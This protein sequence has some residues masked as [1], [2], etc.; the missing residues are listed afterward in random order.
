MSRNL[1]TGLD[2]ATA[3]ASLSPVILVDL[4]FPAGNVRCWN[5][6]GNITFGSNT[7]TGT[8]YLG[9]ISEIKETRD[10]AAN[11]I[12]VS[13]SGIPS[14]LV[15]LALVNNSQGQPAKVYL[16]VLNSSGTFSV[17]PY[18]IF[19]GVIDTCPISDDG[20]TATITVKLEKELIDTRTR[21]RRYTD[22]DQKIDY[23]TDNGLEYV[24]GLQQLNI[25][26]GKATA[27]AGGSMPGAGVVDTS[28]PA[29]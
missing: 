6:Y 22:E 27:P 18:L 7:F 21:G 24:A 3:A 23:P 11:G 19:D 9:T 14:S 25:V 2:T 26:W 29:D 5:G 28:Q 12:Q 10:G 16:G 17:D 20:K 4:T 13:L 8:G 15:S 1:P